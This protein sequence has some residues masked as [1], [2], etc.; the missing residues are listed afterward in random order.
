MRPLKT[1]GCGPIEKIILSG[2][3]KIA[4]LHTQG[5]K[6]R[7]R[8][9]Q[10]DVERRL[11]PDTGRKRGQKCSGAWALRQFDAKFAD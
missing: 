11:R 4:F 6:R 5:Q 1:H 9:G 7:P 8:P 3:R 10:N 2:S